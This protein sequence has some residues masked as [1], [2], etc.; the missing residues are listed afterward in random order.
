[1]LKRIITVM[2]AVVFTAMLAGCSG[3]QMTE[4]DMAMQRAIRGFWTPDVSTGY[5]TYDENGDLTELL[6][7]EFTEDFNY[8]IH[9][10]Y[11]QNGYTM[12]DP[13]ISYSFKNENF[14]V[15]V[16]GVAS[17]ARVSVSDDGQ[18]MKW[19]TDTQTDIYNRLDEESARALG[20]PIY[21]KEA[22]T[23]NDTGE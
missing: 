15:D 13:P 1:M 23:S 10:C 3:Y 20:V 12:T 9:T 4:K 8:F 7:I 22:W 5:N 2:L 6:V 18:T 16:N 17:Y 14:K 21:N 19:I 11:V